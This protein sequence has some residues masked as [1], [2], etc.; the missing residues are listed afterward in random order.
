MHGDASQPPLDR[1]NEYPRSP[2]TH[3]AAGDRGT[4]QLVR[5]SDGFNP[6]A[7][8]HT[9]KDGVSAYGGHPDKP[10]G[11][12]KGVKSPSKVAKP[13]ELSRTD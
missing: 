5:A 8:V 13:T 10:D 11:S 2:F 1:N 3:P 12:L 9:P 4:S 7:A 6:R